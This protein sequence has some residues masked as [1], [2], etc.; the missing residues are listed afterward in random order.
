VLDK[1]VFVILVLSLLSLEESPSHR[2]FCDSQNIDGYEEHSIGQVLFA[3]RRV[4]EFRTKNESKT[5]LKSTSIKY[6]KQFGSKTTIEI[7]SG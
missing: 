2:I 5:A 7:H 4:E 1:V 6:W 3:A